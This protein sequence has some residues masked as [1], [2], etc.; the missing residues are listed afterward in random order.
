MFKKAL[1]IALVITTASSSFAANSGAEK[2]SFLTKV[3]KTVFEAVY[4]G[5]TPLMYPVSYLVE[6][7]DRYQAKKLIEAAQGD[8]QFFAAHVV[9]SEKGYMT[10]QLYNKMVISLNEGDVLTAGDSVVANTS[11]LYNAEELKGTIKING[12]QLITEQLYKAHLAAQ[13]LIF[14]DV[15]SVPAE[16]KDANG[17]DFKAATSGSSLNKIILLQNAK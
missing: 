1:A 6:L 12:R 4:F 8:A 15:L 13:F 7:K 10:S 14:S 11:G 9:S 5:V 16:L 17:N 2:E 3:E